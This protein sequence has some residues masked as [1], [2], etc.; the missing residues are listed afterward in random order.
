MHLSPVSIRRRFW[1]FALIDAWGEERAEILETDHREQRELLRDVIDKLR[2]HDRPPRVVAEN[3][4]DLVAL[5]RQD[6][7]EEEAML[8]DPRVLRDDIVGIDVEA[9]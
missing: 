1:H 8:L 6:M 3:V 9:G 4:L 7:E 5:L 2:D